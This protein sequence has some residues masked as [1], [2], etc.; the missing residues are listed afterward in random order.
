M[1]GG[2]AMVKDLQSMRVRK[3]GTDSIIRDSGVKWERDGRLQVCGLVSVLSQER[4]VHD[5]ELH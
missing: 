1:R 5:V 4:T 2:D 3:L